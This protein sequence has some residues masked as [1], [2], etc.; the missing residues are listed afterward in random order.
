MFRAR[1]AYKRLAA[2]RVFESQV[3]GKEVKASVLK[4]ATSQDT[5]PM[6]VHQ[7]FCRHSQLG[8]LD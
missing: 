2:S 7:R 8:Q 3:A 1:R 6:R 4:R 5:P